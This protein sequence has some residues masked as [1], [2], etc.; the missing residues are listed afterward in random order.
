MALQGRTLAIGA[1]QFDPGEPGYLRR[2]LW[3]GRSFFGVQAARPETRGEGA[4]DHFG[5][6]LTL[7]PNDRVLTVRAPGKNENW[8]HS[9]RVEM[10]DIEL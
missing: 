5:Q 4:S 2:S 7:A 10:F 1:P 6:A 9:G 3:V 8:L